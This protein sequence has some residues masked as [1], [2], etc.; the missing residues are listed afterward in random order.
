MQISTLRKKAV[1]FL[2]VFFLILFVSL[3]DSAPLAPDLVQRLRAEGKLAQYGESMRAAAARGVN[4]PGTLA[5][6]LQL[7]RNRKT[8]A[9]EPDTLHVLVIL[10]DFEDMVADGTY[11]VFATPEMFDSLLFSHLL[12]PTGSMAEYYEEN[13][14]GQV[15]ISGDIAGWYRMPQTYDYYVDG[16]RGFGE[17]PHNAQ[18]L[19]E[20]AVVLAD[21][22]VDFSLYD[23]TG[24]GWVDGIFII[25]AGPGYEATGDEGQI[26][27]HVWS[28]QAELILDGVNIGVYS[29]EPEESAGGTISPIGV[30]CH[31]YG[32]VLGLPD[33]YDYDY[34]TPGIGYWSVMAGGSWGMGGKRPVHFDAWCKYQ[35]GWYQP[36]NI[37][38]NTT[39]LVAPAIQYDPV[40]Y[41]LWKDGI[42]G[43]EYFLVANRQ[44]Y[45]FDKSLP[46]K[47]LMI[48]HVD[49]TRWGNDDNWL[50][51]VDVE[52]ADGRFD[53]NYGIGSGDQTDPWYAPEADHFDDQTVPASR[54]N[55][56]DSTYVAAFNISEID[57]VMTFDAEITLARPYLSVVAIDFSDV[58]GGNGDGVFEG[59]ETIDVVLTLINHW[60]AADDAAIQLVVDDPAITLIDDYSVIGVAPRGVPV[61][62]SA[63]PLRFSIDPSVT[64][65][66][67]DFTFVLTAGAGSFEMSSDR[68]LTIG[69]TQFLIIDDDGSDQFSYHEYYTAVLETLQVPYDL[70][71][72]ETVGLPTPATLAEYPC[73]I[74]YTG[75]HRDNTM[76]PA[77]IALMQGFLDGGGKLLLT[78]QDIVQHIDGLP[79]PSFLTDYLHVAYGGEGVYPIMDGV[80]GDPITD[81]LVVPCN[82]TGGAANQTSLDIVQPLAGAETIF[83][84]YLSTDQAGIRYD[85]AY[86]LVVLGFGMEGIADLMVGGEWN[87]RRDLMERIWLWWQSQIPGDYNGDRTVNAVDMVI[88]IN[89]VLRGAGTIPVGT[90]ADVNGTCQDDMGDVV[91]LVNYVFRN[92]PAPVEACSAVE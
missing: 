18:K 82:S 19:A 85:G 5:H 26:H 16:Q 7:G 47:G 43:P 63:Q 9:D 6:D 33:L 3:A 21:P 80:A 45:G 87:S 2:P 56:G 44:K 39:G 41:R 13:S 91:Y 23:L 57:S 28:I 70:H 1:L 48:Y 8:T 50:R 72:I 59:G 29:M 65:K 30:Y 58:A 75:D 12:N 51:L 54:A 25:H 40:A 42:I 78:G 46:G 90:S 55:D 71:D 86:R 81:G 24:N 11:G 79:D 89:Y 60:A 88:L 69:R 17:Y 35:L 92:G 36:I 74:W 38:T 15:T 4:Q 76:T 61:D 68:Q 20:D 49:E 22:D 53:L 14:W 37:D 64:A 83:T 66:L 34:D 62:N 31:E 73:A 77:R 32:H 52:Q 67:V 84:Y 27:S 10:V